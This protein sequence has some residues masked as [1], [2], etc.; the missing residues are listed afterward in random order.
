MNRLTTDCVKPI[1][2]N[3]KEYDAKLT[4]LTG[5]DMKALAFCAAG[6]QVLSSDEMKRHK[7][8]VVRISTGKGVIGLFAESV[9]AVIRY[10]GAEVFIPTAHDVAGMYEAI[11]YGAEIL[12]MADDD[13]FL[14]TNIKTG[15]VAENDDAVA[16]GYVAALSAMAGGLSG[17]EVLQLGFGRL[18]QKTL[19]KL[20]YEGAT[21]SVYDKDS[22]KVASL[23][24]NKAAENEIIKNRN[25]EQDKSMEKAKDKLKVLTQ[26]P[27]PLSGLIMDVTNE[28]GFLSA[29]DLSGD[30][31]I[32]APGLPLLLDDEAYMLY[33]EKVVHDPLQLGVAV[34]LVM[35][36]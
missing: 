36:L 7:V 4:K 18:G 27:L 35:S 15:V 10:M 32:V 31:K 33:N 24:E 19:E 30:V 28:G 2:Q 6:K 34:M 8:A 9:A 16:L 1:E 25:H 5:M 23:S 26:L 3:L 20:L 22:G 13:R 21:V 29:T 14:A 11:S 17:K 12:F